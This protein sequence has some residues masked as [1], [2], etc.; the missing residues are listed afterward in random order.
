MLLIKSVLTLVKT[1]DADVQD[2]HGISGIGLCHTEAASDAIWWR[3]SQ[4]I[5]GRTPLGR[6]TA[7]QGQ[8]NS[9][10]AAID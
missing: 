9:P 5:T 4:L 8:I 6:V 3:H 1:A 2:R 10:R 7:S